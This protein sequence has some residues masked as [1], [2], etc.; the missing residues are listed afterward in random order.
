M[1]QA[2]PSSIKGRPLVS[3]LA[4]SPVSCLARSPVSRLRKRGG[5]KQQGGPEEGLSLMT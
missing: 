1:S 4:R 3:C 2:Q 5:Q